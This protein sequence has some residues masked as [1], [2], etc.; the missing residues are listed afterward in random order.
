M[1][2]AAASTRCALA[3][4]VSLGLVVESHSL[5]APFASSRPAKRCD[6]VCPGVPMASCSGDFAG[7]RCACPA[8]PALDD[9]VNAS[10]TDAI[11]SCKGVLRKVQGLYVME[12]NSVYRVSDLMNHKGKK[13]R[14]DSLA[15]MCNPR[16]RNTFLREVLRETTQVSGR[17]AAYLDDPDL[18]KAVR[19][20][21]EGPERH[22]CAVGETGSGGVRLAKPWK[23][24][25]TLAHYIAK[26]HRS[27]SFQTA[28]GHE[29]VVNVRLGDYTH[30][31]EQIVAAVERA[32]AQASGI[33]RIVFSGVLHYG[34]YGT[35]V[36]NASSIAES[37]RLM[38]D[39]MRHF[40]RENYTTVLRSEPS[41][42]RDLEYMTTAP[43]L[44]IGGLGFAQLVQKI[45]MKVLSIA[46]KS[47]RAGRHRT[48][49]DASLD[50]EPVVH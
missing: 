15:V 21:P 19:S 1:F 4:I 43:N 40:E 45:R 14:S 44:A 34:G 37:V 8:C 42:D 25:E 18:E 2:A 12:D 17:P 47:K 22:S 46:P 3:A 48:W 41:A 5:R 32:A 16:F 13:W 49:T 24:I 39:L 26:R 36:A 23:L 7:A 27:R 20:Q 30:P 35:Y 38:H 11:D 29:L 31:W 28:L 33:T 50:G 9:E 10:C 6:E